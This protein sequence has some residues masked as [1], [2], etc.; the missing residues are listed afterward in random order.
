MKTPNAFFFPVDARLCVIGG[1]HL[2]RRKM[3]SEKAFTGDVSEWL[4]FHD[5]LLHPLKQMGFQS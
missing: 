4:H 2:K 3:N 1:S 5:I